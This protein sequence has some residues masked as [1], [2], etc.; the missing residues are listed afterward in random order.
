[1]ELLRIL[2][3]YRLRDIVAGMLLT[4]GLVLACSDAE[5]VVWLLGSKVVGLG[6]MLIGAAAAEKHYEQ[7]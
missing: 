7:D 5:S 1:M 6:C 4:V 3:S 2:F